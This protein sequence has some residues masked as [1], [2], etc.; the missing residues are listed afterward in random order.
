[1]LGCFVLTMIF[2][3]V[4]LIVVSRRLFHVS[5]PHRP[6]ATATGAIAVV[7]HAVVLAQAIFTPEGQ[8]FSVSNVFSLVNWLIALTFTVLIFR[9]KVMV[10]VPVVYCCAIVSVGLMFLIPSTYVSHFD[11]QPAVLAHVI[12]SLMAFSTLMIAA[13]Y[14][15]QLWVILNKLKTKQLIKTPSMPPL[16]TLEKQLYQ[17]V[18]MGMV[19]LSLSIGTG[20][21][22]LN[23]IFVGGMGHKMVLSVLAWWV[24]VVMLWQQYSKGC[25][26]RTAII[27]TLSGAVLIFL[28]YFA[29]RIV[30]ELILIG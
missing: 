29:A 24:Y 11:S 18:I 23:N 6:L 27:Y 15:I 20:F 12:L 25:K 8:N 9:L 16:L 14:A 3:F 2:Y 30:N 7:L 21:I 4:A 19:L 10:V 28:A 1:M 17:L 5:G 13:L 26:I 22:S